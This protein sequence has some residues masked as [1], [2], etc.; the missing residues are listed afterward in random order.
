MRMQKALVVFMGLFVL[1]SL[2]F[3]VPSA[4]AQSAKKTSYLDLNLP[5]SLSFVAH[6]VGSSVYSMASGVGEAIK[7]ATGMDVRILPHPSDMEKLLALK[8]GRGEICIWAISSAYFPITGTE[9]FSKMGPQSL[10]MV[11]HANGWF[12]GLCTRGDSEVKEIKDLKGQRVAYYPGSP[13]FM[14][15][16]RSYLSFANLTYD[17]VVKVPVSGYA[18]GLEAVLTGQADAAYVGT[19][20]PKAAEI[21]ASRHGI[22]LLPMNLDDKEGWA[23][24]WKR[25]PFYKQ[26]MADDGAGC[27]P[28]RPVPLTQASCLI[29][30]LPTLDDDIAF[31]VAKVC[32]E[33]HRGYVDAMPVEL[34]KWSLKGATTDLPE[35][36][37]YHPGSI[38]YFK[39]VGA[40]S[41]DAAAW[42]SKMLEKEK[43]RMAGK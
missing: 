2:T 26:V 43:E 19:A 18:A 6:G 13:G 5:K 1:V 17:D 31:A 9:I 11:W 7:T 27:S 38:R 39:E 12:L 23:R 3:L 33:E 10:R 4:S 40:W 16:V 25:G 37:P 32:A 29:S 36:M 41:S 8:G 34:K 42:Q 30:S 35:T 22:R 24:I 15:A 21:E 14:L 28:E 20:A